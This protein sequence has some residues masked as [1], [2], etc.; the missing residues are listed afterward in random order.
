MAEDKLTILAVVLDPH[1]GAALEQVAA[2]AHVWITP[3]FLALRTSSSADA[4]IKE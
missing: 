1:F 3:G 2:Y 4:P